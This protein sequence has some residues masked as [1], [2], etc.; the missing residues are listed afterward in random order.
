MTV[1]DALVGFRL[2]A[3]FTAERDPSEAADQTDKGAAFGARIPFGGPLFPATGP[4]GHGIV[5]VEFG[6]RDAQEVM[7]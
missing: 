7:L 6:H 3:A 1:S 5:F 2:A 4:T